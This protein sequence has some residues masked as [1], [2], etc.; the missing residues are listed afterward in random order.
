VARL[1]VLF[2]GLLRQYLRKERDLGAL[3]LPLSDAER[4]ALEPAAVRPN[5]AFTWISA[6]M[7]ACARAGRLT[8]QRLMLMDGNL[9]SFSDSW[10]GAERIMKTPLPFAYAQHTKWF[11]VLFMFTLPFG[12][13]DSLRW[14]T[15]AAMLLLAFALFGVDEIGVEIEDPFGYDA[16]DLP[17]DDIGKVI[18][19]DVG[20]IQGLGPVREQSAA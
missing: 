2:Y 19:A 12:L 4:A 5:V 8:E 13:S 18:A 15:P 17:L 20:I 11:L 1:I 10:G 9:T 14:W 6:R 16:N 3:G 7:A